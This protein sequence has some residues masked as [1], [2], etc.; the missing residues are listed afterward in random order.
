MGRF[1][2]FG[3][4]SRVLP[5]LPACEMRQFFA[6][7]CGKISEAEIQSAGRSRDEEVFYISIRMNA[8]SKSD[9]EKETRVRLHSHVYDTCACIT[10]VSVAVEC[11]KKSYSETT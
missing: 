6:E 11:K 8:K 10:C 3:S 5:C 9:R 7:R 4:D 2:G 1:A